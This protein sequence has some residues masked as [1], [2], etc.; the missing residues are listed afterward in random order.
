[1][2][3]TFLTLLALS[4][5]ALFLF[6]VIRVLMIGNKEKNKQLKSEVI[7][8]DEP[9]YPLKRVEVKKEEHQP[10]PHQRSGNQP[11]PRVK[12]LHSANVSVIGED[13][14]DDDGIDPVDVIVP[15]ILLDDMI[16]QNNAQPLYMDNS[17]Q[18]VQ[19]NTQPIDMNSSG[20][21]VQDNSQPIDT[22]YVPEPSYQPSYDA[23][24]YT[25][26]PSPSYTP[27]YE[28]PSYDPSPSYDSSSSSSSFE[29]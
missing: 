19:D 3:N 5:L 26:D 7:H 18:Y 27:S 9:M 28:A 11:N 1:M 23:P 22:P 16:N 15:L 14:L 20:N 25:P 2:S 6:I 4:P 12:A 13:D 24:S 17:N 10:L 21:Y 8:E 29:F